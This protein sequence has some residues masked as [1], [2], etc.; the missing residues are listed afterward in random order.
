MGSDGV[1]LWE[2]FSYI[3]ATTASVNARQAI[4]NWSII[5]YYKQ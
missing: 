5:C 3:L 1:I 4:D 2:Y